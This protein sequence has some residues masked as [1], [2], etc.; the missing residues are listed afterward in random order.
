V[1]LGHNGSNLRR[2]ALPAPP[3]NPQPAIEES[4]RFLDL[5]PLSVTVIVW[6]AMYTAPL[7]HWRTLDALIW[8][9]GLTQSQKTSLVMLALTH[10]GQSF[11]EGRKVYPP[12]DWISTATGM[13]E[14]LFIC[15]DLPLVMD[16]YAPQATEE[17]ARK[18]RQAAHRVIRSLGNRSARMR[19]NSD[20][21]AARA[22]L[23]PRALGLATAEKTLDVQSNVGR[24][25]EVP[26]D[27]GSV[28]ITALEG[29]SPLSLA[30]ARN[31]AGGPGLYAQAMSGFICWLASKWGPALDETIR[32]RYA[33]NTAR[34]NFA[35]G[36]DRLTDSY[37]TLLLGAQMAA[38]FFQ[39]AGAITALQAEE[40]V[41]RVS[42]GL[43]ETLTAHGHSVR[44]HSPARR[45]FLALDAM[46]WQNRAYLLP[47]NLEAAKQ[48]IPPAGATLLG[49]YDTDGATVY[50]LSSA[51]LMLAREYHRSMGQ[52]W[53]A[54]ALGLGRELEHAGL[55]AKNSMGRN[56]YTG[57]MGG[58]NI[59]TYAIDTKAVTEQ[60]GVCLTPNDRAAHPWP[61]QVEGDN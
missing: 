61:K 36:Q 34:A 23:P 26:V 51:C 24:M 33:A 40:L 57:W 27:K 43:E 25:I 44:E 37:A 20:G 8:V 14:P 21:R 47:R 59:T 15:K 30:Q 13:E 12:I 46:L 6:A 49:W 9:H 56:G 38:Q 60:T 7:G 50:L 53:D 41:K 2:Y 54:N 18:L 42:K 31:G 48:V 17:E 58:K 39:E 4:L 5:A 28:T 45:L 55:L 32:A 11:I 16:D 10:F 3:H 52:A 35:K 22:P 1:E 19:G 29:E